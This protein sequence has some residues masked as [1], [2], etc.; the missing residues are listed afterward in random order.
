L[1]NLVTRLVERLRTR[2][3]KAVAPAHAAALAQLRAVMDA[4]PE[5]LAFYD[6][7]DRAMI[8]NARY[9]ELNTEGGGAIDTGATFREL[10]QIGL[11]K[12]HYLEATGRE[13]EWLEERM[14]LHNADRSTHEQPLA[15]GRWFRVEERRTPDGGILSVCEDITEIKRRE[16]TLRLMF[17]NNPLPMWI[18]EEDTMRFLDV[19]DAAIAHYGYSREQFLDLRVIDIYAPEEHE[20]FR[21]TRPRILRD[22]AYRGGRTWRHRKSDG[23]EIHCLP[24]VQRI[25]H[26]GVPAVLSAQLDVTVRKNA[27]EAMARARDEAEAASRAKSEFLANMSHEIRTPLNGVAGVA[28]VLASTPLNDQQ[29][30]MVAVIEQSANTLERLLSDLLD[31]ARV[32]S[33]GLEIDVAPFDLNETVGAVAALSEMHAREKDLAFHL[34]IDPAAGG[35]VQGDAAHLKQ[36]LFNLLRNAV[37]FTCEG[38]VRLRVALA[39]GSEGPVTRF[40]VHDTGMGFPPECKERLFTRFEQADGS[41]TRA[42]GGSGLGLAISR[43]LAQLMGGTLDATSEPGRG[44]TFVLELPLVRAAPR[45]AAALGA[46]AAAAPCAAAGEDLR[47][48]LADDHPTNRLVVELMLSAMGYHLTCVENGQEA[49]DAFLTERFDVV[50]MDMQMPVMDGLAAIRAIRDH[51]RATGAQPTPLFTLSANAMPQH[52]TASIEAG[53]DR[54]LTK[55]IVASVLLGALSEVHRNKTERAAA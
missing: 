26:Q 33:G 28:Q 15:D 38:E 8:W 37:K 52:L 23:T 6:R 54:H 43:E 12:G 42:F 14:A 11:E 9:S 45:E 46:P 53:A 29:R 10:L 32:N 4:M 55:P 44:A 19:N 50:L 35:Q 49:L 13:A 1:A 2:P 41:A 21:A 18:V 24:Y 27:E 20:Q 47:I 5:G 17:E 48:L 25:L 30:E 16:A 36:I 39:P 22:G 40:E 51:E 31:L 7:D 3:R 34:E